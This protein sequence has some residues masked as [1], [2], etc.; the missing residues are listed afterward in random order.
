MV[1]EFKGVMPPH[2]TPFTPNYE[3]DEAGLRKLV[4]FWIE[5]GV[6]GLIPAGS[7]GEFARLSTEERKRVFDIV[8][9]ETNG[10][11]PV[12]AGT[13]APGTREV[14]ELSRYAEDAGADGLQIVAPFYGTFTE[15]ELYRHY[16]A[17]AE[18]VN[19]PIMVYN[20]P[21]TSG[22][23]IKPKLL[24]KLSEIDNIRYVKESS[25]NVSRVHEIIRLT[26]GK[27]TVF[28]GKDNNMFEAFCLGAKGWV[29]GIACIIPRMC[30]E[31]YELSVEKEELIKARELY[32]KIIPLGVL[33]ER[34]KFVQYIKKGCEMINLPA[35]PSRPPLLPLEKH[36]EEKLRE[37]LKKI[38]M[39]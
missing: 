21:A 3:L 33:V 5:G 29:A 16:K 24:G 19:I 18:A 14:I 9:D 20:N 17:I 32:Y 2:I 34:S 27:L 6:H 23:D 13:A 22:N 1:R 35:G 15:E 36:E 26:D 7:T 28:I 4:N 30:R 12:L 11:V 37:T 39:I 25:G 10:R 38:G 8:I 31:L